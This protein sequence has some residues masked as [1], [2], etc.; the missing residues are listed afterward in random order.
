MAVTHSA[1]VG[2]RPTTNMRQLLALRNDLGGPVVS[3]LTCLEMVSQNPGM[4]E[5]LAPAAQNIADSAKHA[6]CN[7]QQ[8][9][10]LLKQQN[11][12]S[13][14]ESNSLQRVI[15]RQHFSARAHL[16]STSTTQ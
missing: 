10:L 4:A 2:G 7:T 8:T 6:T 12:A 15:R 5:V 3:A 13:R 1:R 14:C 11:V 9:T 16:P